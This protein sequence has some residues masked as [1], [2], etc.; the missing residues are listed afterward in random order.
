MNHLMLGI[1]DFFLM[2]WQ[3]FIILC[4]AYISIGFIVVILFLF[5]MIISYTV[6]HDEFMEAICEAMEEFN[7]N[8]S[9]SSFIIFFLFLSL[10][11]LFAYPIIIIGLLQSDD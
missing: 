4:K 11:I 6:I 10:F 8:D 5:L 9:T 2:L 3:I 7:F 1:S